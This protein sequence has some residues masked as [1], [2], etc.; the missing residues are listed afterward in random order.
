MSPFFARYTPEHTP[1]PD[2]DYE[3]RSINFL[4]AHMKDI[5]YLN[6]EIRLDDSTTLVKR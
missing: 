4:Y 5:P 6:H 3:Q 2:W 1:P